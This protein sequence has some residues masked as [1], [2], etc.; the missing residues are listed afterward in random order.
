MLMPTQHD[1][2]IPLAQF[3]RVLALVLIG[4]GLLLALS[5]TIDAAF[6]RQTASA[7]QVFSFPA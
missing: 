1:A 3:W 5:W 4:F 7:V 2:I 6:P